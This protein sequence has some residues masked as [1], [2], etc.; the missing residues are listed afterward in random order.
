M[1]RTCRQC[2]ISKDITLFRGIPTGYYR[3][4]CKACYAK[5]QVQR[6]A[7][8][9]GRER[10]RIKAWADKNPDKSR[11]IKARWREKNRDKARAHSIFHAGIRHGSVCIEPCLVCGE[12]NAY[13]HHDDYSKPLVVSWVCP[14]HHTELHELQ[15]IG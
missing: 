7:A 3:R 8:D 5:R 15:A 1:N 12:F 6:I 14:T 11:A 2:G 13:A 9:R 4:A 10:I